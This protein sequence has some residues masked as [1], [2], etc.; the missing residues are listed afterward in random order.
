MKIL[1]PGEAEIRYIRG[2]PVRQ[3]NDGKQTK[4]LE[5]LSSVDV[6]VHIT[7]YVGKVAA[8]FIAFPVELLSNEYSIPSF[9]TRFAYIV[10]LYFY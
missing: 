10:F 9:T 5:I 2:S 1:L 6:T 8:S 3:Y 4:A 7:G